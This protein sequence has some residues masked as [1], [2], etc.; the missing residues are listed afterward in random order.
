MAGQTHR[1]IGRFDPAGFPGAMT[2]TSPANGSV[3]PAPANITITANADNGAGT[4]TKVDFYYG[5]TL[6]GT[7]SHVTGSS[8]WTLNWTSMPTGTYSL[9][10]KATYNNGT[11]TSSSPVTVSVVNPQV[12]TSFTPI[13]DGDIYDVTV[14]N[15]G[16]ILI[17]GNF[18][19]VRYANIVS[20]CLNVARLDSNGIP[21][22]IFNANAAAVIA[23]N[24]TDV[25]CVAVDSAHRVYVGGGYCTGDY[26]GRV[27]R[28][29]SQGNLDKT[30][31]DNS[32][33]IF[34][35]DAGGGIGTFSGGGHEIGLLSGGSTAI[36]VGGGFTSLAGTPNNSLADI[37]I[38]SSSGYDGVV[39]GPYQ[40]PGI[41][42]NSGF[43]VAIA[44][45]IHGKI[46]AGS[47]LYSTYSPADCGIVWANSYATFSGGSGG[48]VYTVAVQPN[49]KI[50]VG[51][52]FWLGRFDA[53]GTPD[54]SFN[55]NV[56]EYI[57][58]YSQ[59]ISVMAQS[60]GKIL[61]S[62]NGT[63]ERFN[64]DGTL[65]SAFTLDSGGVWKM[66]QQP[67]GKVLVVG[68][69]S[70]FGGQTHHNIARFTP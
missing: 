42:A 61:A 35:T 68:G 59:F 38:G 58:E 51:G 32:D 1:N 8:T 57:G 52:E 27:I 34:D 26:V 64:A 3:F 7:G 22:R 6:I 47:Y 54:T 33:F 60:N 14:Q 19:K 37:M 49:Q 69:F 5:T 66:V 28:L 4:V 16:D 21:D 9:M 41:A 31:N 23:T 55:S 17:A 29:N 30:L 36:S 70:T 15:D 25:Y 12:D 48:L 18:T 65:D 2:I 63:L 50:V 43:V 24:F 53:D 67:D 62:D 13:T 45:N 39:N 44:E 46:A 40:Y 11:V 10:A 20:P 56:A